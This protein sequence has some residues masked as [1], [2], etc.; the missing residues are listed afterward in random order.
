MTFMRDLVE[1][2]FDEGVVAAVPIETSRDPETGPFDIY[3]MRVGRIT[4]WF[5]RHIRVEVYNESTGMI[6]ELTCNKRNCAII[7][8]TH[9][10]Q[11]AERSELN[12]LNVTFES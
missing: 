10:I 8:E 12:I 4:Q 5:P 6:Q 11:V 1:S 3:S 2:M 9:F 7:P